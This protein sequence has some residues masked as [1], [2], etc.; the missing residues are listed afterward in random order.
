MSK[1]IAPEV[2]VQLPGLITPLTLTFSAV[3]ADAAAG[4]L[5]AEAVVPAAQ[6]SAANRILL[7]WKCFIIAL[8]ISKPVPREEA[9][10]RGSSA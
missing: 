3:G 8:E 9:W 5:A 4:G 6:A 1:E 2:G 10:I 7:E